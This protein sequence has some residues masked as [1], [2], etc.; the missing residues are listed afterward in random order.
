MILSTALRSRD[1]INAA[2]AKKGGS[3]KYNGKLKDAID[4][5]EKDLIVEGLKNNG[6]NKSKL[7]KTLGISRASLISKVER[8]GLDKRKTIK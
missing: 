4:E 7:A 5:L 1:P 2:A 8:F 3:L 6:W